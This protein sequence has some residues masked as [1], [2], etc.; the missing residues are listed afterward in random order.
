MRQHDQGVDDAPSMRDRFQDLGMPR[1]DMG[2]RCLPDLAV[3]TF[4]GQLQQGADCLRAAGEGIERHGGNDV[5]QLSA[6]RAWIVSD[7]NAYVFVGSGALYE[8]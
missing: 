2:H 6:V 8:L 3:G 4:Q 7:A 1:A 5:L